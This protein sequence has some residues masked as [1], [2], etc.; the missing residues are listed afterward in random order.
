MAS[1]D[2]MGRRARRSRT[3]TAGKN[4]PEIRKSE[5]EIRHRTRQLLECAITCYGRVLLTKEQI[6]EFRQEKEASVAIRL[7]KMHHH[8]SLRGSLSRL[9]TRVNVVFKGA[10]AKCRSLPPCC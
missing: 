6:G 3:R 5:E 4:A 7:L 8:R 2:A 10:S 9:V 1:A